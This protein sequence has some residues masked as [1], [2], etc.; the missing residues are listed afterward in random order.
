MRK[1]GIGSVTEKAIRVTVKSQRG[2]DGGQSAGEQIIASCRRF[3]CVGRLCYSSKEV[4][5]HLSSAGGCTALTLHVVGKEAH[6]MLISTVRDYETV[7]SITTSDGTRRLHT[8]GSVLG[9]LGFSILFSF[10]FIG[11]RKVRDTKWPPWL[12]PPPLLIWASSLHE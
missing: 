1:R 5:A 11:L 12:L 2:Q 7:P 9:I 10:C 4:R 3:R 8:L 6:L